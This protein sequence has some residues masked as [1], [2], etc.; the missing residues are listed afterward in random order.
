MAKI[1]FKWVKT[2]AQYQSGGAL[3]LNRIR[4]GNFYWNSMRSLGDKDDARRWVGQ[5]DLPS[6]KI[7]RVYGA[8]EE[9]VRSN[10]EKV[11]TNWF[12]E[13]LKS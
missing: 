5:V 7:K 9:E 11:V 2:Q 3:L 4:V 6:L 12:A 8:T 13:A 10:M 1:R